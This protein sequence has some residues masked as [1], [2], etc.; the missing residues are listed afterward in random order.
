MLLPHQRFTWLPAAEIGRS[1]RK[2]TTRPMLKPCSP[3]GKAQ[4]MMMSS[5]SSGLA[6]V[7]SISARTTW[8][9]RSSGRT[10]D[11]APL[12]AGVKGERA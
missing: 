8:A 1:A 10:R 5:M 3:S 4:P 12:P 9:I 7:R 2:P 6:P 11:N